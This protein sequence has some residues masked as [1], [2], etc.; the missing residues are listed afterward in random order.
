[1]PDV[2]NS[3]Q[4]LCFCILQKLKQ[5]VSSKSAAMVWKIIVNIMVR[6]AGIFMNM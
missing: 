2:W 5:R 1:M 4:A 6:Q 3:L